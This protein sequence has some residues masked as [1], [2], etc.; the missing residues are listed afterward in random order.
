MYNLYFDVKGTK[1]T[2]Q[3]TNV[4]DI[5]D[6]DNFIFI[7]VYDNLKE[8]ENISNLFVI[9]KDS[10]NIDDI[11]LLLDAHEKH[12]TFTNTMLFLYE[13][14]LEMILIHKLSIDINQYI[15]II[16]DNDDEDKSIIYIGIN[17][18]VFDLFSNLL[19][20]IEN[21]DQDIFLIIKIGE[22]MF[23]DAFQFC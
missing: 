23:N 12:S 13:T 15:S 19:N 3:I 16:K 1:E 21:N 18:K 2:V 22:K 8:N 17:R 7:E 10:K 9:N 14:I 11:Y 20:K 4:L 6:K 5:R